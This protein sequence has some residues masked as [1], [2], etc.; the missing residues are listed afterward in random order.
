MAI[1][2]NGKKVA[3]RGSNGK[4]GVGIVPG[5]STGQVLTKKSN[6][7]YDVEWTETTSIDLVNGSGE[8]SIQGAE[9]KAYGD[10]SF[11]INTAY[12]YGNDSIATGS[13]SKTL[14]STSSTFG[15]NTIAY[16]S[17]MSAF[18]HYN[19]SGVH[20]VETHIGT[21]I[22]KTYPCKIQFADNYKNYYI[23]D[24]L[25]RFEDQK[26]VIINSA[27]DLEQ[28]NEYLKYIYIAFSLSDDTKE[29]FNEI[30]YL[31]TESPLVAV[32]DTSFNIEV[33][34][35]LTII[36]DSENDIIVVGNGENDN[37]RSNAYTL[38]SD[39]NAWF[40]GDVY[41]G[42]NSEIK[43]DEGSVKLVK[44]TDIIPIIHGGTDA[45]TAEDARTNLGITDS[46]GY[47]YESLTRPISTETKTNLDIGLLQSYGGYIKIAEPNRSFTSIPYSSNLQINQE[48]ATSHVNM[49]RSILGKLT[50]IKNSNYNI[51]IEIGLPEGEYG[52]FPSGGAVNF[53]LMGTGSV[54]FQAGE[55]VTIYSKDNKMTLS[56][57]YSMASLISINENEYVLVGA[58]E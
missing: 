41:V 54:T 8:E 39:G 26:C 28:L 49:E 30:Y 20:T 1:Y 47:L 32:N 25:F 46:D 40:A 14:A 55:G 31:N 17:G 48:G 15:D 45:T 6:N 10:G 12:A 52:M 44:E 11:A 22:T 7:D 23:K 13:H 34:S 51:F 43:K 56:E 18:G 36:N 33:K 53:L 50:C 3:G 29:A 9:A 5:G 24:G 19:I 21:T 58:L 4:D 37:S 42:S 16:N 2:V 38:D 27:N 35:K 57:Q